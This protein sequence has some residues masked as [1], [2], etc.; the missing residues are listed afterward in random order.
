MRTI[1]E[2]AAA[3]RALLAPIVHQLG[4]DPVSAPIGA[5]AARSASFPGPV[6]LAAPMR[7]PID[8]PP[9]RNSQMDGFAIRSTDSGHSVEIAPP[10]AAGAAAGVLAPGTAAPIMTGAPLPDGADAVVPVEAVPPGSFPASLALRT[11]RVPPTPAGAFVRD[12]GSDARAG[13][14][15]AEAGEPVTPAVLGL[16]AASGIDT[17]A[18]ARPVRVLVVSTGSELA[19]PS[20]AAPADPRAAIRDANGLALAAALAE[21]GAHVT[22]AVSSDDPDALLDVLRGHA[23]DADVILTTGG[24]SAGAYEVVRQALG[25]RGLALVS[26][27]LQPGGPQGLGSVDFGAVTLPVIAFPGN[28][29]S[30]LVS[31]ELFLRPVL[32]AAVGV[33]PRERAEARAGEPIA[34]PEDK[35][36]VRRG[37]VVDGAIRLVGGASSHLLAHY[38]AA[39]HLVHIPVGVAHVAPGDTLSTWRIR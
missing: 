10:I 16:A 30:A 3:V 25:P 28:P 19:G 34:S 6:A 2:H 12:R 29:V 24:I 4:A 37:T 13:T 22:R 21:V 36:Q 38:A 31:F 39:T 26:V 14:T 35:H 27:A 7:T 23:S 8:L 5:L 17:I 11:L 9:F 1:E 15:L 33:A 20:G 32:A 18:V